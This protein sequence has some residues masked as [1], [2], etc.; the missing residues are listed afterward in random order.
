MYSVLGQHADIV[1]S[2]VNFTH[3]K[4]YLD[5]FDRSKLP[6]NID[7]L[8]CDANISPY[9][10][11]PHLFQL[12]NKYRHSMKGFFLTAKLGEKLWDSKGDGVY[13]EVLKL[14]R[15]VRASMDIK[16][17]NTRQLSTNRQEVFLWAVCS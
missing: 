8:L 13:S 6:A 16:S 4:G 7:W 3:I 10:A 5:S 15:L 2:H 11:L 9:D 17:V 12:R 14:K 1:K